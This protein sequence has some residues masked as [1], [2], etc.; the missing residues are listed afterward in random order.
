MVERPVPS[1]ATG[2]VRETAHDGDYAQRHLINPVLL[3]ML[4]DVHGRR[5]PG[6][7]CRGTTLIA[8]RATVDRSSL[9]FSFM[10]LNPVARSWR[11]TVYLVIPGWPGWL[12]GSGGGRV[13]SE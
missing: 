8:G 13:A 7:G 2:S 3:R 12:E 11:A 4:G 6:A 10:L 5:V 1:R 9:T